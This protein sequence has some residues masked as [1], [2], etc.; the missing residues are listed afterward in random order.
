[1]FVKSEMSNDDTGQ[2]WSNDWKVEYVLLFCTSAR[3]FVT[4]YYQP[5][6]LTTCVLIL[7]YH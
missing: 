7:K 5:F 2:N 1:M 4:Y 6:L 3:K